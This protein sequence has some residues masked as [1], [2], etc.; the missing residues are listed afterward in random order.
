M[1]VKVN[2][3]RSRH[4]R[5]SQQR[6]EKEQKK[7]THNTK[8]EQNTAVN[9]KTAGKSTENIVFTEMSV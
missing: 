4:N 8:H 1:A 9:K 2:V 5:H 7:R 3:S 6:N